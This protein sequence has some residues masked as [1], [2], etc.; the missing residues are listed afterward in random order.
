MIMTNIKRLHGP[1]FWLFLTGFLVTVSTVLFFTL[2]Y[3]F[4]FDRGIFIYT[5]SI[6]I[7]S[8]PRT[9]TVTL[10]GE[11]IPSG[12][13]HD[14]NQTIHVTGVLPGEHLIR[15]EADGFLPWEK[16][17]II[18]SGISTEFWN[19]LLPRTS[20]APELVAEGDFM[21]VFHSSTRRYL[22]TVGERDDETAITLLE[23][24]TGISKRVFSIREY[25]F[26]PEDGLNIE[27]SKDENALL[28]PLRS[29]E[30]GSQTVFL[31]D[32][33]HDIATD[34]GKIPDVKEPRNPRWHPDTDGTFFVLSGN[35][36]LRILPGETAADAKMTVVAEHIS[37][38]DLTGRFIATLD[39]ATGTVSKLPLD[40]TGET[41]AE[42]MTEPRPEFSGF[43]NP[44]LTLYDEKR[45]VVFDLGGGGTLLNDTGGITAT[46]VPLGS[47]IRGIQFSDDGKKLLVFTG[48]EISVVFTRD[49]DVQPT[50][51]AGDTVQIAR[52]SSEV[53]EVRWEKSYEHILF[54]VGNE[55]K[56]AEL[57]S[58]GKR[59]IGT[60][61][62]DSGTV[63][64][65]VIAFPADDELYILSENAENGTMYISS[66]RFPEPTGLFGR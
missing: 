34:L 14:I 1:V 65:Q 52:F 53:S 41:K 12:M 40:A 46:T 38:Y 37:A 21:R 33:L 23:R 30:N 9:V 25:R 66:V 43:R 56:T 55:L 19:I 51:K 32:L 29:R 3:R 47:D 17:V 45:V 54:V 13:I 39:S 60:I 24:A 27:W 61:L 26:A 63:I 62:P 28:I 8:V 15:I 7:K 57:D 22:A 31:F 11:P 49:R 10:D 64:R 58:R 59:N 4:S 18:Q 36:L 20:Y 50:R 2:G 5:G 35:T 48:H 42:P 44:T 16:N 6:T